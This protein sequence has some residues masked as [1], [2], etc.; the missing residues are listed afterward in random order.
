SLQAI[1]FARLIKELQ[2]QRTLSYSP[3]FQVMFKLENDAPFACELQ[4][5]IV[6]EVD[7]ATEVSEFDL[8]ASIAALRKGHQSKFNLDYSTDLFYHSTIQRWLKNFVTL[9]SAVAA[10]PKQRLSAV[11]IA[12]PEESEQLI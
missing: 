8:S 1:P 9:L 12:I 5:L 4:D 7:Y 6:H 3:I 2:P 11:Q 10:N